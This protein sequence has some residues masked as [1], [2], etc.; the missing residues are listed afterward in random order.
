MKPVEKGL[1][2]PDGVPSPPLSLFRVLDHLLAADGS[3][4]IQELLDEAGEQ[5]YGL[6]LL[7]LAL[8]TFIPGVANLLSLGTLALGLQLWW[9]RSH[10]WLPAT[11][12]RFEMQRGRVK[13]LLAHVE[14]R[15]AWL[16]TRSAPRK[17]PGRRTLGFLVSWTAFLAALPVILP[18][19]NILPAMGLV[20]FG[21]ALLEEW[22]LL[23][24]LGAGFSL[25]TTIYFGLSAGLVWEALRAVFHAVMS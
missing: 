17:A 4:S 18:F 11:I 23:A 10:L 20:L 12:Q 22:P 15:L 1:S 25:V 16:G 2:H 9:G 7:I 24:W 14:A 5:T 6:A 19:A 8:L 21:V 3:V 13:E